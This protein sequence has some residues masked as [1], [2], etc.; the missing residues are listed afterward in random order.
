MPLQIEG[1][2]GARLHEVC[3]LDSP[4][5]EPACELFVSLF[6]EDRR[7]LPYIRACAQGRHPS[8]PFTHDH[9][10][11]V[12]QGERW[13]GLRVFSYITTRRFGHG[14]YIGFL[15]ECRGQGLGRWLV[16]QTLAQLDLDAEAYANPP[17]SGYLVEVERAIDAETPE[18]RRHREQRLQFHRLCGGI[19]LP[20]PFVEPVMIQGVDYISVQ[21]LNG[22]QPRPMHLVLIPSTLGSH[23]INID[24]VEYLSGIYYDVYRLPRG[25]EFMSRSLAF[26]NSGDQP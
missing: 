6:P 17:V 10:W 13:V 23:L 16:E 25:H 1:P 18:D 9:V 12:S 20:V 2:A 22:D 26:L 19:I 15:P 24:L 14:A 21:Q 7:Y 11:L 4:L 8:H 3:G 5:L